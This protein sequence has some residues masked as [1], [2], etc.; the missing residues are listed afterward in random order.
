[1]KSDGKATIGDRREVEKDERGSAV[2]LQKIRDALR[3]KL[4]NAAASTKKEFPV[5]FFGIEPNSVAKLINQ[6]D[7]ILEQA[8][9]LI[10]YRLKHY[11]LEE[12]GERVDEK[13]AHLSQPLWDLL[14][15]RMEPNNHA[16]N[17][18]RLEILISLA[19]QLKCYEAL[20]GLD[21]VEYTIHLYGRSQFFFGLALSKFRTTFGRGSPREVGLEGARKKLAADPKQAA[22]VAVF[23]CWL[24]WQKD[25]SRYK[26]KAAF[27]R[28]MLE[29]F[30]NLESQPVIEGWCRRWSAE[31]MPYSPP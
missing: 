5:F 30:D 22:K 25:S 19:F 17:S 11:V 7:S 9:A 18:G 29:K 23:D 1:M 21:D 8:N 28:D 10:N 27:A 26:S 3:D 12:S 20:L 15:S 14:V 6:S 16:M 13:P 4:K 24:S 31:P 2:E